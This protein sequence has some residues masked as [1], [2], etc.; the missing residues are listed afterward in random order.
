MRRAPSLPSSA[1]PAQP[2]TPDP[3]RDPSRRR[4]TSP[5][6]V[7]SG[8]VLA[9]AALVV[10]ASAVAGCAEDVGK[11]APSTGEPEADNERV[12]VPEG[13]DPETGPPS[14]RETDPEDG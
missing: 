1:Q 4:T 3:R 11:P 2:A 13:S 6:R 14:V 10:G 9:V 8:A 7:R 12:L 5:G